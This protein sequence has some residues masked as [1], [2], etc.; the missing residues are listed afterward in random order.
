MGVPDAQGFVKFSLPAHKKSGDVKGTISRD[1]WYSPVSNNVRQHR[2][3]SISY[4][5][6][7]PCHGRGRGFESRRPRH[8][9]SA[10][11]KEMAKHTRVQKGHA[12]VP[13]LPCPLL[14]ALPHARHST[15]VLPPQHSPALPGTQAVA[16]QPVLHAWLA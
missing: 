10:T 6:L 12:L 4:M 2:L 14:I 15:F 1:A 7:L 9:L 13:S 5:S 11:C 8:F 3:I 16:R